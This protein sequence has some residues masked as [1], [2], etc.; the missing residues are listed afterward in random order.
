MNEQENNETAASAVDMRFVYMVVGLLIVIVLT[1]AGLWIVERGQKSRLQADFN[2]S[3]KHLQG[4]EHKMQR[5]GTM[6]AGQAMTSRVHRGELATQEVDWNGKKKTVLLLGGEVGRELGFQ[7][8]DV[9]LVTAP[10]KTQQ[11]TPPNA[12]KTTP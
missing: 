9:I 10:P 8:G 2:E 3:Q 12:S 1:M 11:T 7:P 6:L 4:Q 5:L